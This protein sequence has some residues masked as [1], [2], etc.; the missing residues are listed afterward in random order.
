MILKE[1]RG[2]DPIPHGY[3]VAWMPIDRYCTIVAPIPI[4]LVIRQIRK[5]Y[6]AVWYKLGLIHE[7][8]EHKI[9]AKGYQE[10]RKDTADNIQLLVDKLAKIEELLEEKK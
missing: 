1:V 5:V 6:Y 10:G 7:L 2:S 8:P 3:G 9:F 4:N